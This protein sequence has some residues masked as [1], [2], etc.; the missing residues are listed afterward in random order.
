MFVVGGSESRRQT[1]RPRTTL[2]QPAG[3][4]CTATSEGKSMVAS[5][6]C[7]VVLELLPRETTSVNGS[8]KSWM[9]GAES[10][11]KRS[12]S[13]DTVNTAVALLLAGFGSGVL[14]DAVPENVIVASVAGATNDT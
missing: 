7:A 11:M 1:T 5:T 9:T 4:D 10:A 6:S 14:L 2:L 13:A 8:N 3:N 12:G